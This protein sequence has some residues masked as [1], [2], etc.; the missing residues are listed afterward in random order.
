MAGIPTHLLRLLCI[1]PA[2][3]SAINWIGTW[4]L[5]KKEVHRF[6]KVYN[7]TLFAPV[8]TA[9]LFLAV[10]SLAMGHHVEHVNGVPFTQFMASGLIIMTV[11]QNAFA[12]TSSTLV[13]G[14]VM[15]T[16]IDY[17]MPPLS[18]GETTFAMVM[19]GVTR[20]IMVGILVTLAMLPFIPLT[21]HSIGFAVFYLIISSML[22][23]LLGMFTGIISE[24]FDQMSAVTSYVI[25]PLSFLSGT[26]YSVHN[27]PAILQ[28]LSHINPFFYMIDG[29]R[30]G[31]TGYHD[32]SLMMGITIVSGFTALLWA[33][34]YV[35]LA[36][37]YRIK[38]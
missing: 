17:I 4:T 20:G 33:M 37:G 3:F 5:Y 14:K 27:L 35:M 30:Y 22:L 11:V 15:G 2:S 21:I 29:F 38:S 31:M 12:N 24:T 8:V 1:M 16:I 19:G 36:K 7:Q 32:G 26:F 25:T 13:M 9:L 18:A 23:A 34:V 28:P 6:I 10:F